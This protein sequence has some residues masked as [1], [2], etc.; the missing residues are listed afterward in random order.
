MRNHKAIWGLFL[1]F[2][3]G[4]AFHYLKKENRFQMSEVENSPVTSLVEKTQ[5]NQA[6]TEK[7]LTKQDPQKHM[8]FSSFS[9]EAKM[10]QLQGAMREALSFVDSQARRSAF[11]KSGEDTSINF[12]AALVML[13]TPYEEPVQE[14][15]ARQKV[16]ALHFL[17]LTRHLDSLDGC[18][19]ILDA[20]DE[21]LLT[22]KE[23]KTRLALLADSSEVANTCLDIDEEEFRRQIDGRPQTRMKEQILAHIGD[24]E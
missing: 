4:A 23:E 9:D 3:I 24:N 12:Q 19:R 5:S 15:Q 2:I 18:H 14:L 22:A 13:S 7:L 17:Q 16:L 1:L 6:P 20:I 8:V 11:E 10:K 21:A